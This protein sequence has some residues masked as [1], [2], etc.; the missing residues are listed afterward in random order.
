M[1]AGSEQRSLS[2]AEI[3]ALFDGSPFI[4]MLKLQCLKIDLDGECLLVR[5]P[6]QPNI[7]RQAD[8]D[9]FHGG[10]IA[11]LIDIAGDFAVG[12]LL[13]GGVP[14]ASLSIDYLRRARGDYLDARAQVRRMGRTL[15]TV[16]IDVMDTSGQ[17]VAIGRGK[18]V[19]RLG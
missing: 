8:S 10:A 7:K 12:M 3:Q 18:Y 11:S 4:G 6:L 16:D 19:P 17:V 15:S 14:T 2:C 9:Y 5:M 1:S 13:G